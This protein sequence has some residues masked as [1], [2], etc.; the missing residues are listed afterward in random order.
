MRKAHANPEFRRRFIVVPGPFSTT[1]LRL[2]PGFL[3]RWKFVNR[4]ISPF[5]RS[6][7]PRFRP[8][9]SLPPRL[10]SPFQLP[11]KEKLALWTILLAMSLIV[12]NALTRLGCGFLFEGIGS[13]L[14]ENCNVVSSHECTYASLENA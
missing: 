4:E 10:L 11:D 6:R 7:K 3:P 14:F 12:N 2:S 9:L 5:S 13:I 1:P 8:Y